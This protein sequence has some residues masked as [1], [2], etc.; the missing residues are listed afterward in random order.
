MMGLGAISSLLGGVVNVATTH[1]ESKAKVKL[2]KAEAESEVLKTVA[3][4]ESKWEMA[5]ANAS[6]NSWK[7]EAWTILFI[8]IILG[9]FIPGL[10]MHI[11][12][13]FYVLKTS[14]PE[15]FKYAVYM[16]ISA[17]FGIRGI[18]KFLKK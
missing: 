11:E 2:A 7:D 17:S 4:H 5:M 3:Q 9:C 16:S 13:G 12:T 18:G 6:D 1:L 15:W 8:A 10:Q 14:T